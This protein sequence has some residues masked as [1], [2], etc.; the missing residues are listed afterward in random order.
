LDI[1]FNATIQP[2]GQLPTHLFA[3]LTGTAVEFRQLSDALDKAIL[4]GPQVIVFCA[5]N[6]VKTRMIV[7]R[8]GP[9]E[10]SQ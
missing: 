1:F 2:Q 4:G 5:S 7:D 6:G 3:T 10:Q 8:Q 9:A